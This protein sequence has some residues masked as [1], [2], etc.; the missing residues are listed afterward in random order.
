MNNDDEFVITRAQ[1]AQWFPA[2]HEIFDSKQAGYCDECK[3]WRPMV[4]G[5]DTV[6]MHPY[7]LNM[8]ADGSGGLRTTAAF[9]CNRFEGKP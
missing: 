3:H 9:G 7:V 5:T 1:L 2:N 4:E 8:C 6:C